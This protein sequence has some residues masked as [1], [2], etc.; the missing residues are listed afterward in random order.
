[1]KIGTKSSGIVKLLATLAIVLP[2]WLHT[3][4]ERLVPITIDPGGWPGVGIE[5]PDVP[6]ALEA[7]ENYGPAKRALAKADAVVRSQERLIL[8]LSNDN[9]VLGEENVLLRQRGKEVDSAWQ[10]KVKGERVKWAAIGGGA[11]VVLTVVTIVVVNSLV[12]KR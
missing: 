9:R 8:V 6:E 4:P 3:N 7:L 1:M 5:P 10:A 2:C 11:G 12:N